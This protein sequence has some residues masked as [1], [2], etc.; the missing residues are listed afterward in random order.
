[1]M[2][3][4]GENRKRGHNNKDTAPSLLVSKAG[5]NDMGQDSCWQSTDIIDLV[6][7]FNLRASDNTTRGLLAFSLGALDFQSSDCEIS[8]KLQIFQ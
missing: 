8:R 5:Q 4:L 7:T 2:R 3:S 1:M 6:P